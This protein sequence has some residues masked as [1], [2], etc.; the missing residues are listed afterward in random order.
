MPASDSEPEK[1][2]IDEMMDRLR[3]NGEGPRDG[4]ATL[5][6]RDDGSQ[7]YKVRK[8]KR[9]SQQPKKEKEKRQQRFRVAQVLAAVGLVVLLGLAFF[10]SVVYLNTGAYQEKVTGRIREWT[11]AEPKITQLR[12]TP[13]SAS[14]EAVELKWPSNSTLESLKLQVIRGG[15]DFSK[16]VGGTWKGPEMAASAGSLVLHRPTGTAMPMARPSGD[17]PF[18]FRYRSANF[19]IRMGDEKSPD[20]VVLNCEAELQMHDPEG[21]ASH[22]V[23]KN[24]LL[25]APGWGNYNLAFASFQFESSGM[26]VGNI[27]LAP[28]G[29][30]KGEIEIL[31]PAKASVN[32]GG[33][34]SAAEARLTNMPLS[35][36][37]GTSF[38]TWLTA[39]VESPENGE[40]GEVRLT[41]GED[42][43]LRAR[44]PFRAV[45]SSES[46]AAGLPF[47]DLLATEMN[48]EW[49]RQPRFDLDVK[50]TAVMEKE[51]KGIENLLL[52][53][54]GRLSISG[55]VFAAADGK[56]DGE[57]NIGLP[58]A[59]VENGSPGLRGAFARRAG[60]FA[61]AKV[62]ISGTAGQPLDDLAVQLKSA[63]TMP[64]P[65]E[66]DDH[67]L[68]QAFEELIN[69]GGR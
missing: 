61:W 45:T 68:E 29:A 65:A 60:G 16:L 64:L 4:E 53:A 50:G 30:G 32:L 13:V 17:L 44:I 35:A 15:L 43:A 3:S 69:P 63:A 67:A 62:K 48:E 42:A 37:L 10:A 1:Y 31:N 56:L 14:A 41:S 39:T 59:G 18:Q 52:G 28:P 9:R 55:R 12:V 36:L 7:V 27:R 21:T 2:S 24:G 22:L 23:V 57:L 54:R 19:N 11:G 20:F 25:N 58:A 6:T 47:F 46:T 26:R 8:R 66:G 38:G 51:R 33:G 49:Y 40:P 34:E 5:V